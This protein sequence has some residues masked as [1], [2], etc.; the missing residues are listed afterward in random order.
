MYRLTDFSTRL[1]QP[2]E[3]MRFG[4]SIKE[5]GCGNVD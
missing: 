3:D 2:D 4:N 5:V 1:E